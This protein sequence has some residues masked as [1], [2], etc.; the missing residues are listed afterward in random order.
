MLGLPPLTGCFFVL[1]FANTG[2]L[3]RVVAPLRSAP[4]EDGFWRSQ[5]PPFPSS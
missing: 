5:N 2:D 4:R 1:L 3:D